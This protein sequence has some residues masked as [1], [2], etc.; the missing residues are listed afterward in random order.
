MNKALESLINI[1]TIAVLTAIAIPTL[2]CLPLKAKATAALIEMRQIQNQCIIN[3]HQNSNSRVFANSNLI[4]YQ[5]KSFGSNNCNEDRVI[6]AIP[7]DTKRL[8]I[9]NFSSVTGLLTYDFKGKVGNNFQQC[10]KLICNN[11]N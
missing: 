2:T 6:S 3:G 9:F 7:S 1:T 4:G 5:I 11:N 10:F 8:P